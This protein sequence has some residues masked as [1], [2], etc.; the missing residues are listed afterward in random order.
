MKINISELLEDSTSAR[1]GFYR[2]REYLEAIREL[3]ELYEYNKYPEYDDENNI[4]V[5]D[6]PLCSVGT[7]C[8]QCPAEMFLHYYSDFYL[9]K[10]CGFRMD[11]YGDVEACRE[12]IDELVWLYNVYL[13]AGIAKSEEIFCEV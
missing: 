10:G 6:C 4:D 5:E 12:R 7:R 2:T 11:R 3:I 8:K 9:P 1:P 13:F